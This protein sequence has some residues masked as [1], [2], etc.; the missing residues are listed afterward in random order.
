[1]IA[2]IS[3]VHGNYPALKA[4]LNEIDNLNCTNILSL[5]DVCGYYCMV[6]EC[7]EELRMRDVINI[8]GNHDYYIA[9]NEKCGRSYTAN[10]CLEYQRK[11]IKNDNLTWI[12]KSVSKYC[13]PDFCAVHGGW[14][15]YLDEYIDDFSFLDKETKIKYYISGHTH[16][17]K[18]V[19]GKKAVYVNPGS[20]GQPR[21][22]KN[23]AAFCLID[24]NQE[25]ILKRVK[26][27]IDLMSKKMKEVGFPERVSLCL[28]YGVKIGEDGK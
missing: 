26:Y 12:K 21:D 5:G 7:I 24:D 20:V 11:I 13:S 4:V 3:D 23:T 19:R 9:N 22:Y 6:N 15:D 2:I 25:I 8:M 14:N 1:M 10:L 16:I 17:Q 28:Y 27:D 18:L